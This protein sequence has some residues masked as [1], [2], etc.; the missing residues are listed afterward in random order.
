V[1]NNND[2]DDVLVWLYRLA[3]K[4]VSEI[5]I[6]GNFSGYRKR[7]RRKNRALTAVTVAI[8]L[9]STGFAVFIALRGE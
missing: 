1:A 8:L 5:Q 3:F 6:S 4:I 9:L 2:D 7:I